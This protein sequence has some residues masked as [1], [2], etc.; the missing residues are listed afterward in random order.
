M[1]QTEHARIL[2]DEKRRRL[3]LALKDRESYPLSALTETKEERVAYNH[4][5]LPMLEDH[6][7]IEWDRNLNSV[8]RGI[9]WSEIQPELDRLQE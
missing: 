1:T 7:I 8:K 4:I 6:G 9:N 2:R 3:L 5:H